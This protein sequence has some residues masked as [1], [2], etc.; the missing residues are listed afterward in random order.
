MAESIGQAKL[1]R[2]LT[3]EG[4]HVTKIIATSRRGFP[5]LLC[6]RSGDR[7]MLIECKTSGKRPTIQQQAM[8]NQLR[9]FGC[10][11]VAWDVDNDTILSDRHIPKA[12]TQN[13]F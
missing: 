6:F 1:I 7:P 4:W 8:L 13:L 2:R 9:E 3:S 5:D 11:A 10:I 12:D